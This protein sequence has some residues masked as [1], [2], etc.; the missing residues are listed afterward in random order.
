MT[1]NDSIT[2]LEA[3]T[4]TKRLV[5]ID[6]L[7]GLVMLLMALDHVRSFFSN[8]GFDALDIS[9]SNLPLFFTRWVTH[10]CAPSFVFLAGIGVYLSLQRG[11]NRQELTYFLLTRGVWLIFLDLTVVSFSWIFA[12]G[13]FILGVLWVIGWSMIVLAALIH[14]PVR[15]V[16][17]V[18]ILLIAGHNLFD[19]ISAENLGY[20]DWLW[21]F[22][23]ER[24]MFMPFPGIL[25]IIGY[26]LV[27]WVGVMAVGYG[28]G[29][30]FS[31]TKKQRLSWLLN[32]GLGLILSFI[33]LRGINIYG[34]PQPWS[35]KS[36]L[37]KTF[38]SF[39]DCEK[40]PPSLLYLLITLGMALLILYVFEVKK[41]RF[42][43]PLITFGRVPLLFYLI[44]LWLI[45][46][47][48]IVLSLP[49]YGLKAVF[50]PYLNKSAMPTEYGYNLLHVYMIWLVI[51]I[52]IYPICNWF[53]NYKS[54]Y[55]YWWLKYF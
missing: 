19:G 50:L 44:H 41:F 20:L 24:N 16:V 26:P 37:T 45:H 27:P 23:H 5:S 47:T 1:F 31:K 3:Q 15:S 17:I 38:L 30:V 14:L 36:N 21:S 35:W 18:G 7:R 53:C 49:K 25:L 52:V 22:L 51:I 55:E 8:P 13:I 54:S 32:V 2:N 28:W 9:Q 10:L 40:Y 33:L 46:V 34:D 42:L 6:L 12:P 29:Q 43:K 11:K 39:I 4:A 48:A